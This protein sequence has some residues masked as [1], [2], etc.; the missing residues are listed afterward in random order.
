MT[1]LFLLLG[2]GLCL[3]AAATRS[4]EDPTA[5]LAAELDQLKHLQGLFLQRQYAASGGDLVAETRGSFRLLRPGYF[6][7][8]VAEPDSQL[9]IADLEYLWHFD[10]DLE[11]VTRRPIAGRDEMSPLQVLGGDTE[12]MAK[13]YSVEKVGAGRFQLTPRGGTSPGFESLVIILANG[14]FSGMEIHDKLGQRL[15]I[16]FSA[17]DSVTSLEPADFAFTPPEGADLFFYD[18]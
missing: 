1:R 17:V 8:E 7:W 9:V 14:Q 5:E 18:Q 12:L 15:F 6:A 11:T 4:A 16:E 3:V 2:L 10:R 13:D